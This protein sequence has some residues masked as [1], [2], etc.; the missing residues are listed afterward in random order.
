[1]TNQEAFDRVIIG[2]K[3][4]NW[5]RSTSED[6]CCAYRG[7]GGR[8]CA[9]GL[10]IKDEEYAPRWDEI[11]IGVRTLYYYKLLPKSLLE[12]PPDLLEDLQF[13]HDKTLSDR[14]EELK[15]IAKKHQLEF[16][17]DEEFFK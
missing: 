9:V 5:E 8:K 17:Y 13:F 12:V 10:L 11:G 15:N 16:N 2:L 3:T 7:E 4:Q 1:M 14:F 6:D